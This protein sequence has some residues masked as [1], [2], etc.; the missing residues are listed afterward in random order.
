MPRR[1]FEDLVLS[2]G[3]K[4]ERPAAAAPLS[5]RVHAIAVAGA[6]AAPAL[7]GHA[8]PEPTAAPKPP[9]FAPGAVVVRPVM[10]T[11]PTGPR[12][13][14]ALATARDVRPREATV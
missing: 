2:S 6:L 12:R 10:Q 14:P 5:A 7:V 11:T 1:L 4:R 3:R 8:L 9:I 13:R